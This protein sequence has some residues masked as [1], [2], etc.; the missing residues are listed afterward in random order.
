TRQAELFG[1]T[2]GCVRRALDVADARLRR[3]GNFH[4]PATENEI[5]ELFWNLLQ[6][7]FSL[8]LGEPESELHDAS[9]RGSARGPGPGPP[10]KNNEP[11]AP[12]E[13]YHGWSRWRRKEFDRAR[14]A[15]LTQMIGP[16]PEPF[17]IGL[18]KYLATIDQIDSTRALA[19]LALH[20]TDE[21]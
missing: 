1:Q 2:V 20:A 17:Q 4:D 11:A 15:A 14:V 7:D 19:K 16:M 21:S 5:A 9:P 12:L 13:T 3:T 8:E 10:R 18:A 6:K